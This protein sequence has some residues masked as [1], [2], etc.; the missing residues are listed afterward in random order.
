M[1]CEEVIEE[2]AA[3][4]DTRDAASLEGHLSRCPSCATWAKRAAELDRLWQATGPAEPAPHVW[5][6]LWASVASSLDSSNFKEVASPNLFVSPNESVN[7]SVAKPGPKLIHRPLP[8]SFGSRLWKT[9]G[10]VGLAKAAAVLLVAG[11]T[12]RFFVPPHS[13]EHDGIASATPSPTVPLASDFVRVSLPSV[14]I[15]EGHL[16]MI[17]A[18]PKNPT[19]VDRTPKVTVTL[20]GDDYSYA[21]LD[22]DWYEFLGKAESL[23]KP[24][25]AMKE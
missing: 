21:N 16:V 22:L 10:V 4:T 15:E 1:R 12:L 19:V 13:P 5:D 11:L 17:L 7:G 23:G 25:V 24:V 18:D 6:N 2:L 14:D 8:P 3:P 9:I 20:N